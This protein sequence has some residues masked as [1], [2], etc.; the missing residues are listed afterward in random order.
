M[1]FLI[2]QFSLVVKLYSCVGD[3]RISAK[4]PG[5]L[6]EVLYNIPQSLQYI[7][8]IIYIIYYIIYSYHV[9]FSSFIN[10]PSIDRQ[11]LRASQGKSQ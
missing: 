10:C 1:F 4:A 6:T 7:R 3:D 11:L 2:E 5:I 8:D 9:S